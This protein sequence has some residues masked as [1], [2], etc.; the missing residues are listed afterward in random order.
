VKP[1]TRE[2]VLSYLLDY[3][4][5][6]AR[7]IARG[8]YGLHEPAPATSTALAFLRSAERDGLVKRV[9]VTASGPWCWYIPEAK[10]SAAR[11]LI[12]KAGRP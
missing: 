12:R 11:R 8:L 4:R 2:D 6:S 7:E 5:S 10:E 3:P 9:R 1:A